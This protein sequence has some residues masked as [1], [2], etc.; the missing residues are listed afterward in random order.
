MTIGDVCEALEGRLVAGAAAAGREVSGGYV[1]DL[2]SDAMA[3]AREGEV[4]I[5]RQRHVN[6][7]AVARL[8]DL[9][10]V[11][12]VSDREPEPDTAARAEREGIPLVVTPLEAFDAAGRLYQLGVR[13][14]TGPEGLRA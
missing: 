1:S 8:R 9:A 4:W 13:G 14:R 10:G 6:I 7:V 11:V 2:L 12:L 5:T 3:H